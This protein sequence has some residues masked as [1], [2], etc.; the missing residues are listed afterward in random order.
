ML[1]I[2]LPNRSFRGVPTPR[3]AF[4]FITAAFLLTLIMFIFDHKLGHIVRDHISASDI[5]QVSL[6]CGVRRR[7]SCH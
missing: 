2:L 6:G 4:G 5:L 3:I 7:H 1:C